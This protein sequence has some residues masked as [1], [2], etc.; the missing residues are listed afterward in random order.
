[1]AA[2]GAIQREPAKRYAFAVVLPWYEEAPYVFYGIVL[3]PLM[4]I[5]VIT[6]FGRKR[7]QFTGTGQRRPRHSFC[8]IAI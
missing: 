2:A 4:V 1:M 6:G 5:A 8:M 3:F 7:G